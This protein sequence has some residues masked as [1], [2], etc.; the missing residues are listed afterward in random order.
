MT[1]FDNF[2]IWTF[3]VVLGVAFWA[4]FFKLLL[5]AAIGF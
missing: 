4:S 1:T 5:G 2:T 3:A